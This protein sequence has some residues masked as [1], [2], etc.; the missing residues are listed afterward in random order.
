MSWADRSRR[1][2]V[3]CL[4]VLLAGALWPAPALA[5]T[6]EWSE[7][8]KNAQHD[9]E[10]PP[11]RKVVGKSFSL[12]APTVIGDELRREIDERASAKTFGGDALLAVTLVAQPR[13]AAELASLV[14]EQGGEV[15]ATVDPEVFARVSPAMLEAIAR[16]TDILKLAVPQSEVLLQRVAN[17][18]PSAGVGVDAR[19]RGLHASGVSGS[20]VTLAVIDVGGVTGGFESGSHGAACS[21]IARSIA[22]GA[23]IVEIGVDRLTEGRLLRAMEQARGV[24]ARIV[25]LSAAGYDLPLDGSASLDRAMQSGKPG[26]TPLWVVAA[27]NQAGLHW[28]GRLADSNS[29]GWVDVLASDARADQLLIRVFRPG[30]VQVTANWNDWTAFRDRRAISDL[31]AYLYRIDDNA[32]PVLIAQ[33]ELDQAA[34]ARPV[35]RIDLDLEPGE[36]LFGLRATRLVSD[37]PLHVFVEG[38]AQLQP[39]HADRSLGAPGTAAAALT[40]GVL[41]DDGEAYAAYSGRGPTDDGRRK[42]DAAT[43]LPT[44]NSFV[45]TSAATPFL[46]GMAALVA[47]RNPTLTG[48]ALKQK[49][50]QFIRPVRHGRDILALDAEVLTNDLLKAR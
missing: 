19:M 38:S 28:H 27:G 29:N 14:K 37:V 18:H 34:G 36:Y 23:T 21:A 43:R 42:P 33:S 22:P 30:R 1:A 8:V 10:P 12:D 50:L 41:A 9:L 46:A 4:T 47:Q 6:D 2:G 32:I 13:R 24:G 44:G 39:A 3:T 25:S 5:Q 49:V 20:G 7:R 26:Q 48:T 40:V 11:V 15:E 35:E 17:V 45:G 16:R 31:D